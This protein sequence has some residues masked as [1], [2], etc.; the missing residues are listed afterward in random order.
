MKK[1]LIIITSLL[2]LFIPLMV[3]A[4]GVRLSNPI[5][6]DNFL[7]LFLGVI[8]I[9]LGAVGAFALFIF[10]WG[11]F[12][13][14]TSAGNPETVKKAKDTLL[15]ATLGMVVILISWAFINYILGVIVNVSA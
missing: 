1:K 7:C 5:K 8:R 3:L 12:Q 13:M 4:N 14:L 11:G 10:I 9:F 6:C 15:W 2:L